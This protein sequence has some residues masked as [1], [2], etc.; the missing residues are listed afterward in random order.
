MNSDDNKPR[1]DLNA[2]K[3]PKGKKL[4]DFFEF[5]HY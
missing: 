5:L 3:F 4:L 1:I 2:D